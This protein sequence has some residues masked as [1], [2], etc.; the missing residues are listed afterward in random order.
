MN[1]VRPLWAVSDKQAIVAAFKYSSQEFLL[2]LNEDSMTTMVAEWGCSL[3][4]LQLT[5]VKLYN[6]CTM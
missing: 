1:Y 6:I 4:P 2:C 5:T 3:K